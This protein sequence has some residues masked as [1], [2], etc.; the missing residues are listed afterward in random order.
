MI[1]LNQL[2]MIYGRKLLFSDVNLILNANTRYALVGAN[3]SGKST[4]LRLMTGE[5]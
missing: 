4:L 2:S 3:G 1:T 5:E